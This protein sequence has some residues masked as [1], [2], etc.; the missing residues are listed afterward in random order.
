MKTYIFTVYTLIKGEKHV[1]EPIEVY[2]T[3]AS[4]EEALAQLT[5]THPHHHIA[6]H[7]G[8]LWRIEGED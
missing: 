2:K 6:K 3:A 1:F 4:F 8:G 5:E 7:L